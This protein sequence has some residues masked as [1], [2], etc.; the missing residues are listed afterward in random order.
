MGDGTELKFYG[1]TF[2]GW[3]ATFIALAVVFGFAGLNFYAGWQAGMQHHC[4]INQK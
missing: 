2:T 1:K 4:E 3:T